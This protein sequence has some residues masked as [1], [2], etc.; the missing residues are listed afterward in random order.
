MWVTSRD[1]TIVQRF[2][3][4]EGKSTASTKCVVEEEGTIRIIWCW[5]WIVA[6]L[7]SSPV[8]AN[9]RAP[10]SIEGVSS[11]SAVICNLSTA[12]ISNGWKMCSHTDVQEVCA[13]AYKG[14]GKCSL[15]RPG[16]SIQIN[17]NCVPWDSL[18]VGSCTLWLPFPVHTHYDDR[19]FS[20]IRYHACR[21]WLVALHGSQWGVLDSVASLV[22]IDLLYGGLDWSHR[23]DTL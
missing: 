17:C 7:I 22:K 8:T 1:L 3:V 15:Q 21:L 2:V 4:S 10:Q 9:R 16:K 14:L 19:F 13:F 12:Q 18:S 20:R 5:W 6:Q 23:N 11:Q